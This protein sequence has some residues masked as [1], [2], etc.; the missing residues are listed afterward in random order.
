MWQW[1][2]RRDTYCDTTHVG[3]AEQFGRGTAHQTPPVGVPP[4]PPAP[5]HAG[6]AQF[7][8]AAAFLEGLE[9]PHRA[10]ALL[11]PVAAARP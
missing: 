7:R 2:D 1:V 10:Q 8:A 5:R 6:G 11:P 4:P 9:R 3:F